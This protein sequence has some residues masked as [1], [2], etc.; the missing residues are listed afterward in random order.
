VMMPEMDGYETCRRLKADSRLRSIPVI[1]ITVLDD[2]DAESAGLALGAADYLSKPLNLEIARQRIRNLLERERLRKQVE[3]HRDHLEELVQALNKSEARSRAVTQTAH[4]AIITSGSDGNIVGWNHGAEIIF[5]YAESEIM[6]K[7]M[8]LLIPERYRAAH[9]EGMNRARSSGETHIIGK[10]VEISGLRKNGSEFPVEL[11][12]AKWEIDDSWFVT[13]IIRDITERKQLE[14][15]VRQLAFYDTLTELANR[16]L[17]N[18]RLGQSIAVSKRNGRYGAL[19]FLDLDNFK[20]LN[21]T[22]GHEVGDL[23]LIE[24]ANR[25][26]SC[27]RAVDTVARYGGDEFVVI[28]NELYADKSESATRACVIAEKLRASLGKPYVLQVR[29]EGTAQAT[30]EHRCTASIGVALFSKTD[31]N[32]EDV[33]KRADTAMYQA[34]EAGR[35]LIRFCDVAD[36]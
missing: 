22:H 20:S 21:D 17:L 7:P 25:L 28:I 14:D 8:T 36:A 35:N 6:G 4:D 2:S 15:Q 23:L 32:Q 5:G 12:L 19:M 1:F 24:A 10:T 33:L 16:R 11:S 29:H 27:V 9:I 30:V 34:K 3:N 26:K 13:G 18:D 31:T